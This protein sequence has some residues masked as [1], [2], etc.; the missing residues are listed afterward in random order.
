MCKKWANETVGIIF[1]PLILIFLPN[2][3][4]LFSIEKQSLSWRSETWLTSDKGSSSSEF[5]IIKKDF[6]LSTILKWPH[7]TTWFKVWEITILH[8]DWIL[9]FENLNYKTK[10]LLNWKLLQTFQNSQ[11]YR[12]AE[13][14]QLWILISFRYIEICFKLDET[15]L[16]LLSLS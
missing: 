2:F 5:S 8:T 9:T 12:W 10:F 7:F 16:I 6:G 15:V 1:L 4:L 3:N 14:V 11:Y 13:F